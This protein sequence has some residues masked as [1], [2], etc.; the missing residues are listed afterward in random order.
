MRRN[1]MFAIVVIA[2]AFFAGTLTLA[3][4][5]VDQPT[6]YLVEAGDTYRS[7]A[8]R[9]GVDEQALACANRVDATSCPSVTDDPGVGRELHI[10]NVP[11]TVVTTIVSSST[12]AATTTSPTT[13]LVTDSSTSTSTT[14]NMP[15]TTVADT[16]T[17]TIPATTT[18]LPPTTTSTLAPGA[19]FFEPFASAT[20]LTDRFDHGWSGEWNAGALFGDAA[21]DWQAD[22]DMACMNPNTSSRTIHLSGPQQANDAAFFPCTFAGDGAKSHLMTTVNTEGYVT[23]WFSPKQTFTNVNKVCWDQN[24]TFMGGGKWTM[25]NFLIPSEY[26][27]QTDLGYTSPEFPLGGASSPKGPAQNGVKVFLGG[28]N[29]FTNGVM[30]AGPQGVGNQQNPVTDKAGR[31]QH[32]VVDNNNGTVTLSMAQPNGTTLASTVPGNIPDGTI[33]IEFADD[34]YNPD[35]HFWNP[36]QPVARDSTGLY[37]THWDN[38]VIVTA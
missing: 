36:E 38:L 12:D 15:T 34:N 17:T 26:Q 20:A 25:V 14:M 21:N 9:F 1:R 28:M 30:H 2:T 3:S 24:E 32:C 16:T 5:G 22:H 29:S 8:I 10:P 18:T 37:T 35:K 33:R 31:Y 6:H 11:S 19:P 4:A 7:I 27:G 13:T 23:V